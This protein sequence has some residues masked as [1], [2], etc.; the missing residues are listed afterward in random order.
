[1]LYN[2]LFYISL[3][4]LIVYIYKLIDSYDQH[5]RELK[6]IQILEKKL[7]ELANIRT[8]TT[9]CDIPNLNTPRECYID[10]NYTCKWNIVADR[11]DKIT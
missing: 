3:L 6:R 5:F 10:S 8:K 11:C 9:A 1:M 4:V 7:E 2:I